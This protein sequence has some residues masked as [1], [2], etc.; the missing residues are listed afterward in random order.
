[1]RASCIALAT[2]ILFGLSPSA[3]VCS[4]ENVTVIKLRQTDEALRDTYAKGKHMGLPRMVVLDGKG[5]AVYSRAGFSSDLGHRLHKALDEDRNVEPRINLDLILS[6]TVRNDGQPI[7]SSDLPP[8]DA[9]VIDYWADW[10]G[11]CHELKRKLQSTLNTWDG[12]KFV[13]L[14]IESDPKKLPDH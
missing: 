8:A 7:V 10:C 4:G 6:E 12:K 5:Q 13:W 9:Y 14:E 2:A 11:P 3:G 1:M